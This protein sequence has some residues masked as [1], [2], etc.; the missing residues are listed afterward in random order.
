MDFSKF[1][2]EVYD[3]LGVILPG[4]IAI[5]EGWI[6]LRGWRQFVISTN[7]LSATAFTV[8]VIFAFGVGQLIQEFGDASIKLFVSE[9]FFRRARDRFWETR[10]AILVKEAIRRQ[11]GGEIT[12]VDTALDFCL[13]RLKSSFPKRNIFIA[14]S[15]L[16]RSL[17]ILSLLAIVPAVK[18]T[19]SPTE[20]KCEL[21]LRVIGEISFF[22]LLSGL[23]WRRM[24][25]FREQADVTVFRSYLATLNHP[26]KPT[27]P[28]N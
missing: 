27:N 21:F 3:L 19:W 15:D 8:L 23:A 22:V 13:T 14:T 28:P 5:C 17:V 9:R 10:D 7:S 1:K 18:T 25:R 11:L 12:A 4:I 20:P 26:L 24:V 6:V 16:C 2:L